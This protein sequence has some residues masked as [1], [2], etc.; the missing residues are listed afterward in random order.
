MNKLGLVKVLDI[1]I[2]TKEKCPRCA[3]LK[4]F[5]DG[6]NVFYLEKDIED[7]LIMRELLTYQEIINEFCD[8]KQCLVLTP[9]I[10]VDGKFMHNEFFNISGVDEKQAKAILGIN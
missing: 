10:N 5:L 7:N 1:I 3:A 8:D 6:N 2:Y 9:V 4:K